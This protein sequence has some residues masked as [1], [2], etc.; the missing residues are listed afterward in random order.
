MKKICTALVLFL[1]TLITAGC[2]TLLNASIP[3]EGYRVVR[4]V[5]YGEHARQRMDFYIPEGLKK[6]APVIIFFY[7]GSWQ[8]GTKDDYR[9]VGQAFATKGFITAVVDYRLYPEVYFPAFVEDSAKAFIY[10]HTTIAKHGGDPKNM[11]IAGHSAGAFNALMVAANPDYLT[12]AGGKPSWI[13]GAI[14]I[15]GPYDFLPMTDPD[16]IAIFS[17]LP[18]QQTQPVTFVTAAMPPMFLATGTADEIVIPRNS[19]RFA[20]KLATF[21]QKATLHR[22]GG[23]DHIDIIL[24][25]AHGFRDKSPLLEDIAAFLSKNTKMQRTH[26]TDETHLGE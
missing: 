7:G 26:W 3:H 19:E 1:S 10:A 22:Y 12:R 5:A 11:F 2:A 13:R 21:G 23:L 4:D 20:A 15:A 25:L 17:K 8:A 14:G 16:I 18:A 9:F 24:S 6:P